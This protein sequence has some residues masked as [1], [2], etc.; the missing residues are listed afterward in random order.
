MGVL[1]PVLGSYLFM[2]MEMSYL[3]RGEQ[4]S[5]RTASVCL[6]AAQQVD[7]DFRLEAVV[8]RPFG[9]TVC[10]AEGNVIWLK[11]ILGTYLFDAMDESLGRRQEKDAGRVDSTDM[12]YV[13]AH[14]NG[15][16]TTL[17][18]SI[19]FDVGREILG[20]GLSSLN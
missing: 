3:R 16:D 8:C 11:T 10:E 9:D 4:H 19:G 6:H 18:V 5:T 15:A 20:R 17:S 2:G 13:N 14:E 1:R 12:V 7:G